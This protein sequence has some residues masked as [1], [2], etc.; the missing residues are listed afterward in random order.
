MLFKETK[1]FPMPWPKY[2]YV[3]NFKPLLYDNICEVTK[4]LENCTKISGALLDN[5]N[6]V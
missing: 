5:I 2:P 3:M 6:N 1:T 4:W